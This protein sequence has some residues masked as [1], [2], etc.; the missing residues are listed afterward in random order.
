M[1]IIPNDIR[2]FEHLLK[3]L[4]FSNE[5]SKTIASKSFSA[6][7]SL[8]DED[9]PAELREEELKALT[10]LTNELNKLCQTT[11]S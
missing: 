5:E 10:L 2:G 8:R 3:N 6:L 11:K 1:S 9:K 7:T 4:G